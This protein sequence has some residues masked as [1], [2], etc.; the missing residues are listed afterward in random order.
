M[1][2]RILTTQPQRIAVFRALQ[3]GDLLCAIPALRALRRSVQDARITWIGLPAMAGFAARYPHLHDDYVGFPGAP[4]YPEQPVDEAAWP[5]FVARLREGRFDLMIQM[6]GDGTGANAMLSGFGARVVAGFRP[7]TE[8]RLWPDATFVDW[9]EHG[10]EVTSGLTLMRHLGAPASLVED[11]RLELPIRDDERDAWDALAR[12]HGLDQAPFVCIHPGARWSSRRWPLERFVEVASLLA[13]MHGVRLVVT[14]S[15][16]EHA[17]AGSLVEALAARGVRA[18]DLSGRT[19]LGTLGAMLRAA[20]LLISN[21]TGLSHV[22]AAVRAPSVVVASG[23]DVARWAPL[24]TARHRVL[25]HDVS[26]RPCAYRDCPIDHPC[27][28]GVTVDDVLEAVARHPAVRL[29]A[30]SHAA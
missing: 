1:T 21:D 15:T 3:L 17:L 9:V 2:P 27:A 14:G 13:T 30:L 19:S 25:A 8:A 20:Q 29:P 5:G 4:G 28:K 6:Q 18:L 26:C 11:V 7:A 23:S 10:S 22:A 24:D 12:A 16:D